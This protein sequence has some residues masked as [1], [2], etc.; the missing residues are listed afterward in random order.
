MAKWLR[1]TSPVFLKPCVLRW[2]CSFVFFL[3][4]WYRS[5][6]KMTKSC[7]KEPKDF[8][9]SCCC[10]RCCTSICK[11]IA[12]VICM[13]LEKSITLAKSVLCLLAPENC[14]SQMGT[15]FWSPEWSRIF[16]GYCQ[17]FVDTTTKR[18]YE[19]WKSEWQKA[20]IWQR[21]RGTQ[22]R[23]VKYIGSLRKVELLMLSTQTMKLYAKMTKLSH[24]LEG[25]LVEVGQQYQK[26]ECLFPA[27]LKTLQRR[28]AKKGPLAQ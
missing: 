8:T 24:T 21:K 27:Y 10:R 17:V 15:V 11:R 26:Q 1:I 5:L 3:Q 20:T 7:E 25:F 28:G 2:Q 12:S 18:N 4:N 14:I 13:L 23:G 9:S 6:I 19:A 16:F 22:E